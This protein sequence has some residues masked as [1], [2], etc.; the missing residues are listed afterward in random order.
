[1]WQAAER[2]GNRHVVFCVVSDHA[3]IRVDKALRLNVALRDAGLIATDAKGNVKS[4]RA[5]A[6]NGGGSSAI[7]L[8]ESTDSEARQ[9][10]GALLARL[11]GDPAGG[12]L[13]VIETTETQKMGGSPEAAFVVCA[14][15]GYAI[16]TSLE[17]TVTGATKPGGTHGYFPELH[18]MDSS[19]FIAGPGIVAGRAPGRIDMRDIAPTLARFLGVKLPDAEGRDVLDQASR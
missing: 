19:F 8:K 17:G 4:W 1:V 7:M 6:W 12:V 13:R 2:A 5:I 15:P 3:F 10:A 9:K 18:E 14:R 11:A 16:S